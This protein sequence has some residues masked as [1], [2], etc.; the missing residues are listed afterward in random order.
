MPIKT[1]G[2]NM[3]KINVDNIENK[4]VFVACGSENPSFHADT[5]HWYLSQGIVGIN[6]VPVI[7]MT[8]LNEQNH[9]EPLEF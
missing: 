1:Q 5:G 8:L 7:Q 3:K 2:G 9:E 4:P 6:N